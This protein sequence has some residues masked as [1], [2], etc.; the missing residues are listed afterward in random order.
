VECIL[1]EV[2]VITRV[3]W[4]SHDT[5]FIGAAES[6]EVAVA[7]IKRLDYHG[8][9]GKLTQTSPNCEEYKIDPM[10]EAI[11]HRIYPCHEPYIITKMPLIRKE[12]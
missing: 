1:I 5:E 10:F 4:D 6:L 8:R 11:N 2:W 12:V 9:W 7:H 3:D